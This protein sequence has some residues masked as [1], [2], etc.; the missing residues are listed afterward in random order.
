V[1]GGGALSV[2]RDERGIVTVTVD[3]A[4]T[5]NA[6]GTAVLAGLDRALTDLTAD[7]AARVLVLTG[8]GAVF[9]S[10]ADRAEIGDPALVA[11]SAGLLARI[12]ATIEDLPVP[13]V[14]RVN[15]PAFGAGLALAAAA[16]IAIAAADA[17]FGLPEVRLGLVAGPAA[18]TCVARVGR[19]AALDLLLTGR[20]FGATEAGRLGLVTAVADRGALDDAVESVI[21]DLLAGD[22]GALAV[23]R[24]LVRR[25]TPPPLPEALAAAVAAAGQGNDGSVGSEDKEGKGRPR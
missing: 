13:V 21:A 16:D 18:V 12:L 19:T 25:L 11:R 4:P 24:R 15:G 7:P 14:C 17:V 23:T 6:L 8:A 2:T 5:R 1:A 22:R 9:S 10:G 3:D 20:R